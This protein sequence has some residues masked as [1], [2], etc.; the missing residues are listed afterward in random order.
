[1][2]D[3]PRGYVQGTAFLGGE[4]LPN[5]AILIVTL[6][7]ERFGL[8]KGIWCWGGCALRK[9]MRPWRRQ[10]ASWRAAFVL[11]IGSFGYG[12]GTGRR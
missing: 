10:S 7:R 3:L 2:D 4:P 1:M 8:D 5:A 12:G 6:N 11:R 9:L